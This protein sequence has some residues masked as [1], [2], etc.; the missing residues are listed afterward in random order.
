[1]KCNEEYPTSKDSGLCGAYCQLLGG[2]PIGVHGTIC[3]KRTEDT[4]NILLFFYVTSYFFFR[5]NLGTVHA[6][7]AVSFGDLPNV[8]MGKKCL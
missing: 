4:L 8:T 5:T 6:W 3:A 2:L 7:R 1:M